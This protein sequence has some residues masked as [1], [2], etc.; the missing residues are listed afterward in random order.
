MKALLNRR[1]IHTDKSSPHYFQSNTS[2]HICHMNA[3]FSAY[4]SSRCK[5]EHV[6]KYI[7][8]KLEY[9]LILKSK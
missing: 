1:R 3:D 9:D 8:D 5:K 2:L 4:N 7:W 6:P